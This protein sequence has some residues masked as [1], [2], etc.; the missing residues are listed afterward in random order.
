MHKTNAS[1]HL[2]NQMCH[3]VCNATAEQEKS[4]IIIASP[5]PSETGKCIKISGI[6][7]AGVFLHAGK[8]IKNAANIFKNGCK[9][10]ICSFSQELWTSIKCLALAAYAVI[11]PILQLFRLSPRKMVSLLQNKLNKAQK[12]LHALKE[13]SAK[14]VIERNELD[15][16]KKELGA[17]HAELAAVAKAVAE[18]MA[19]YEAVKENLKAEL[20]A[21]KALN[22]RLSHD[23]AEKR[24]KMEEYQVKS[25]S[26]EMLSS[27]PLLATLEVPPLAPPPPLPGIKLYDIPEKSHESGSI[28]PSAF[29][30]EKGKAL[31]SNKVYIKA[32]FNLLDKSDK[33]CQIYKTISD[34]EIVCKRLIGQTTNRRVEEPEGEEFLSASTAPA[35]VKWQTI[36]NYKR[37]AGEAQLD[38]TGELDRMTKSLHFALQYLCKKVLGVVKERELPAKLSKKEK[39]FA[40]ASIF[41]CST[42]LK[43]GPPADPLEGASHFLSKIIPLYQSSLVLLAQEDRRQQKELEK[44]A[45]SANNSEPSRSEENEKTRK[46]SLSKT[47][48]GSNIGLLSAIRE[49]SKSRLKSVDIAAEGVKRKA[50][51]KSEAH[52]KGESDLMDVLMDAM[53]LRRKALKE[54]DSES[55]S[56]D[57]IWD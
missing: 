10:A 40:S 16:A 47:A 33:F 27:P 8:A 37:V 56:D 39:E 23:I 54:I 45:K 38:V 5:M 1:S 52:S 53:E 46:I 31:F 30:T 26:D 35:L 4:R 43:G 20:E 34:L 12:K 2:Y 32:H 3:M 25:S 15:A 18:K 55:D 24:A 6:L 48:E 57:E 28:D 9:N 7:A 50:A 17:I 49:D 42:L 41:N 29:L 11:L 21:Q 44:R 51:H 14:L 19:H 22:H 13:E 36:R